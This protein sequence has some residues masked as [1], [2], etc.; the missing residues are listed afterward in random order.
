MQPQ[1][2]PAFIPG[3]PGPA[4][5]P[6]GRYLPPLPQAIGSRWLQQEGI[7]PGTLI[8]DPFGA[9]PQLAVEAARAGHRLLVAVNNPILQLILEML[10]TPPGLESCQAVLATLAASRIRAERLEP[11]IRSLYASHCTQCSA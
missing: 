6:L 9:A 8:L 3:E 4:Q 2:S 5:L 1:L 10:A 7:Q 11:H